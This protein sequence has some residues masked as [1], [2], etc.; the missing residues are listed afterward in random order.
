[1]LKLSLIFVYDSESSKKKKSSFGV[2]PRTELVGP[3]QND[4]PRESQRK[5]SR[6][7]LPGLHGL[8]PNYHYEFFRSCSQYVPNFII[9]FAGCCCHYIIIVQIDFLYPPLYLEHGNLLFF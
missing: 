4:V 3:I 7:L 8:W 6:N 5:E 1:M 2:E 9:S